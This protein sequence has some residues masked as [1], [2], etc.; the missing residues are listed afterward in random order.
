M[1]EAVVAAGL[2]PTLCDEGE[3]S[4]TEEESLWADEP[5]ETFMY[6]A[7]K[8]CVFCVSM[9]VRVRLRVDG[10]MCVDVCGCA[11]CS[12]WPHNSCTSA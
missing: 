7:G 12:D 9:C 1:R 5:G 10:W 3:A 8:R 2:S 6:I 11:C 4:W